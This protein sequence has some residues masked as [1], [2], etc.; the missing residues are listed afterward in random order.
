MNNNNNDRPYF[1]KEE[2]A[3]ITDKWYFWKGLCIGVVSTL[4]VLVAFG[5]YFNY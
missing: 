1:T 2:L 4:A 5:L 3:L